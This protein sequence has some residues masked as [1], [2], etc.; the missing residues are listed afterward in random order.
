MNLLNNFIYRKKREKPRRCKSGFVRVTCLVSLFML[1]FLVSGAVVYC[2]NHPVVNPERGWKSLFNEKDLSGWTGQKDIWTVDDGVIAG[3]GYGYLT[4]TER[5]SNFVLDLEFKVSPGGNG[6]VVVRHRSVP[7]SRRDGGIEMQ[8]F[9][10]HGK[11]HSGKHDCGAIY[12]M[13]APSKNMARPAGQ[14]NRMTITC[15]E[16]Q[17][18]VVLNGEKVADID[19]RQWNECG[20]NPDGTP[21]KYR[22]AV[23]DFAREGFILFQAH[24]APIW[25]RNIYIRCFDCHI[26]PVHSSFPER[27]PHGWCSDF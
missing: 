8:I 1:W 27:Q 11:K 24:G 6:G 17:I 12:D 3:E 14:W 25:Y 4:S 9:D 19:L 7:K 18:A 26:R 16:N 2:A 10:S 13:V 5:Y 20:K 23:K 15:K 21:N 22:K